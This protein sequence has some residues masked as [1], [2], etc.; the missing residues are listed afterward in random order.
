VCWI[1]P[2]LLQPLFIYLFLSFSKK[3]LAALQEAVVLVGK[4]FQ[5]GTIDLGS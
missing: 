2:A 1:T 5:L 3:V 4:K